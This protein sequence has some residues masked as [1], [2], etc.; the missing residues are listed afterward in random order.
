MN[1]AV[2]EWDE[3]I[4]G[5]LWFLRLFLLHSV[6]FYNV[7]TQRFNSNHI[8]Y[9]HLLRLYEFINRFFTFSNAF[10]FLT[11]YVH[12]SMNDSNSRSIDSNLLMPYFLWIIMNREQNL[13]SVLKSWIINHTISIQKSTMIQNNWELKLLCYKMSD[14]TILHSL[15]FVNKTANIRHGWISL[16]SYFAITHTNPSSKT[17]SND[18]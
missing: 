1:W 6:F 15:A 18:K 16:A 14:L 10:I 12:L 8:K 17:G 3:V 13:H 4:L 2:M 11:S 7:C 5:L 9:T